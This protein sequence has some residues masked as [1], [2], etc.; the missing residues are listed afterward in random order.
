MYTYLRRCVGMEASPN[1]DRFKSSNESW[2]DLALGLFVDEDKRLFSRPSDGSAFLDLVAGGEGVVLVLALGVVV[3]CD[4][5]LYRG[6]EGLV[7]CCRCFSIETTL[8][9][10]LQP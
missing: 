5:C 4:C 7:R 10:L 2:G 1:A 6:G 9:V 3:I 8:S